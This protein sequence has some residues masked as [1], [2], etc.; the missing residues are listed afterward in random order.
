MPWI[1]TDYLAC[2]YSEID[3]G[4]IDLLFCKKISRSSVLASFL[5]AERG[6]GMTLPCV[7]HFRV[8]AFVLEPG[9]YKKNNSSSQES[10]SN[11]LENVNLNELIMDVSGERYPYSQ[12]QVEVLPCLINIIAPAWLDSERWKKNFMKE[13][14][15]K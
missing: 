10:Q 12:I 5:D 14:P 11:I 3:N 13:Y 2:P 6:V 4:K 9:S 15:P 1:A 8:K 7:E